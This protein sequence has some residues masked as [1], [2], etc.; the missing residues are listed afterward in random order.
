MKRPQAKEKRLT[1]KHGRVALVLCPQNGAFYGRF[2]P[3]RRRRVAVTVSPYIIHGLKYSRKRL[4]IDFKR[5]L[6][7][8]GI[9][10]LPKQKRPQNGKIKAK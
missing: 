9:I 1:Q 6:S 5:T 3:L 4:K 10:P 8:S 2:C 7:F